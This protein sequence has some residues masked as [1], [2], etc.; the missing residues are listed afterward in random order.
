MTSFWKAYMAGPIPAVKPSDVR[1]ALALIE[2]IRP[3]RTS[4][5]AVGICSKLFAERC[6]PSSDVHAVSI[7]AYVLEAALQTGLLEEW[8]KGSSLADKV[9]EVAATYPLAFQ[10]EMRYDLQD[11][12]RALK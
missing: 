4:E 8:R 2:S 11:F 5:G 6:D 10:P 1:D 3:H 12:I 7:R 9:F